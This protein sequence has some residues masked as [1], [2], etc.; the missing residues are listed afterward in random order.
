MHTTGLLRCQGPQKDK[1]GQKMLKALAKATET[2]T[3]EPKK[4]PMSQKF[5]LTK[6]FILQKIDESLK[7][8]LVKHLQL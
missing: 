2:T 8:S 7:D 5:H 1:K 3:P 4:G 6:N